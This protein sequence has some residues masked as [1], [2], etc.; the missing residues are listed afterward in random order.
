MVFV[1][2][3]EA[4]RVVGDEGVEEVVDDGAVGDGVFLVL[5]RPLFLVD[6]V[7]AGEA[8]GEAGGV[9]GEVVGKVVEGED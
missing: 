6:D 2:G 5:G 3:G 1:D 9:V 4:E 8:G 7:V